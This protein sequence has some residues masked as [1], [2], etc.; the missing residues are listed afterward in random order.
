M[1]L[2]RSEGRKAPKSN[3]SILVHRSV[4]HRLSEGGCEGACELKEGCEGNCEDNSYKPR[5][6]GWEKMLNSGNVKYVD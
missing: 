5:I 3:K 2:R 6:I 4:Q 1:R